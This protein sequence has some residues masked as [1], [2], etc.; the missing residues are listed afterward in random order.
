MAMRVPCSPLDP[1]HAKNA[2]G[3]ARPVRKGSWLA[4]SGEASPRVNTTRHWPWSYAA[5]APTPPLLTGSKRSIPRA[6]P[7][8]AAVR[9]LLPCRIV[10]VERVEHAPHE[11]KPGAIGT[12]GAVVPGHA[13]RNRVG[14][15]HRFHPHARDRRRKPARLANDLPDEQP[16]RVHRAPGRIV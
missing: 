5:C 1:S 9:A 3:M 16:V 6:S 15:V 11:A 4:V 8:T 13:Q 14:G 7:A 2:T 10:A 12:L